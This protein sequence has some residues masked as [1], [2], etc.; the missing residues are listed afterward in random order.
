M[1]STSELPRIAGY[2]KGNGILFP[3]KEFLLLQIL[4]TMQSRHAIFAFMARLFQWYTCIVQLDAVSIWKVLRID[5]GQHIPG[6]SFYC[7]ISPQ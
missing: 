2:L 6:K 1:S 7:R 4:A 5:R 3:G